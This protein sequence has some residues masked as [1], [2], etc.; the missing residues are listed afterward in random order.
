MLLLRA[1]LLQLLLL[2]LQLLLL[3]WRGERGLGVGEG[4]CVL[5]AVL[6][7]RRLARVLAS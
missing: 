1:L 2:Q 4:R 3:L 6:L 5:G 7:P